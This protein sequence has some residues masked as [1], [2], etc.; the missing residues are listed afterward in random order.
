MKLLV[1]L[2]VLLGTASVALAIPPGAKRG[3][4]IKQAGAGELAAYVKVYPKSV[5][6]IWD[7]GHVK[8]HSEQGL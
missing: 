3:V 4:F 1:I 6:C 7:K 8:V 5:F 2:T